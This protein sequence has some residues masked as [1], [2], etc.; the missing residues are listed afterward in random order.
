MNLETE[1]ARELW[2]SIR[3]SYE[4]QAWSNAILDA[5][6]YLGDVLRAKTGLQSDG[7]ALVGQS[8]GG[9]APKL[10]LNRLQTESEQSV[11]AGVEQLL[12]GLYQAVRN[13]RS[14]ERTDDTQAD[15][16]ALIVFIDYL[17]R[18]IGHAR[19][20][21]SVEECVSR[22]IDQNFVPNKRYADLLVAEIPTR[23]RLQVA[24]NVY[25]RKSEGECRK[26][27]YFFDAIVPTLSEEDIVDL[28]D[29]ISLEL[30]EARE[31]AVVRAVLQL[32]TPDDWPKIN[33]VARLRI[34]N[35]LIQ[36]MQE[37]R[38]LKK[39]DKC[40]GGA[41]ATWSTGF[42][43]H[44]TLKREALDTIVA[45]LRSPGTESQEYISK[46]CFRYIDSLAPE[47]PYQLRRLVLERLAA[48]DARFKEM[49]D[50]CWLWDNS[51]W[52]DDIQKAL[53]AFQPVEAAVEDDD[54]PF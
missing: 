48:G 15:A 36:N 13:P 3:R 50:S 52:G 10:R 12:R 49:I 8:L 31:E 35:L 19:P 30:R 47:P 25:Q 23:Q 34:E 41:L 40:L 17:L 2:Q 4:S 24:L 54:V 5:I 38:Y 16:D 43:P 33:E 32:V 26:L 7:T 1:I 53:D 14:H 6:H 51:R 21:F 28:F 20:A 39:T 11:Q 45:K 18:L 27:R 46:F 22:V 42:W 37:G 29:A 9:K 44:F